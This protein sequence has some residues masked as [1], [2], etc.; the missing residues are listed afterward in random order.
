MEVIISKHSGFC[1]GVKKAVDTAYKTIEEFA[2]SR[3][4][5]T[6]GQIIHNKDVTDELEKKGC[7]IVDD[8][9]SIPESSIL[10]VRSHGETEAFFKEAEARNIELI[11]TT[12]PFVKRIHE[13]VKKHM[14]KTKI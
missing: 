13:F 9:S 1:F 10:I 8:I 12:C 4:I 5:Y 2:E 14:Q 7:H 11:D 6:H 3:S